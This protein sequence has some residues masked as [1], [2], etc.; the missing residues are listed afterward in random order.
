MLGSDVTPYYSKLDEIGKADNPREALAQWVNGM[1]DDEQR[2]FLEKIVGIQVPPGFRAASFK[3]DGTSQTF[4]T[5]I[6]SVMPS[7]RL[8]G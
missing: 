1:S 3:S 7:Q 5:I 8:P 2:F 4:E 6:D